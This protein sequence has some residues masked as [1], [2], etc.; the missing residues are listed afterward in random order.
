[1]P[2]DDSSCS[3][4]LQYDCSH[5]NIWAKRA[6]PLITCQESQAA[7]NNVLM[8]AQPVTRFGIKMDIM[9]TT[10]QAATDIALTHINTL[11]LEELFQVHLL[12]SSSFIWLTC[13]SHQ[14]GSLSD[15]T[16]WDHVWTINLERVI[17]AHPKNFRQEFDHNHKPSQVV[18]HTG[19]YK[20]T[21]QLH[22]CSQ[23]VTRN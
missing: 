6:F 11:L 12:T 16:G 3:V 18:L 9:K 7:R 17:C 20:R 22:V 4:Q 23:K 14:S 5:M 8:Q 15:R 2:N 13:V 10:S 1:M 19:L 21:D